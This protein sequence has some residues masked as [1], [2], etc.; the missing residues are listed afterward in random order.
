MERVLQHQVVRIAP[1]AGGT[2]NQF[3][4]LPRTP[5]LS[6]VREG[7]LVAVA[8]VKTHVKTRRIDL[9][10]PRNGSGEPARARSP[11]NATKVH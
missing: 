7:V 4:S 2:L 5:F 10:V 1:P 11:E 8:A 6:G 9:H 3:D